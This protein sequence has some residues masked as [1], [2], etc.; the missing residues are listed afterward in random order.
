MW[1]ACSD[2]LLQSSSSHCTRDFTTYMYV[3]TWGLKTEWVG[4]IRNGDMHVYKY[5][6]G[7]EQD[8]A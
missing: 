6:A 5:N 8:R 4:H 2:N 3:R 1:Q 7:Y